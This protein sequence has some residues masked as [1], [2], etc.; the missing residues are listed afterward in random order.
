MEN[1]TCLSWQ[2][3]PP[4]AMHQ[5][6]FCADKQF[7]IGNPQYKVGLFGSGLLQGQKERPVEDELTRLV[8]VIVRLIVQGNEP[9]SGFGFQPSASFV[10]L[11]FDGLRGDAKR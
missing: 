5:R 7:A 10:K 6:I 8:G 1:H 3:G 2:T 4:D 11:E 9:C